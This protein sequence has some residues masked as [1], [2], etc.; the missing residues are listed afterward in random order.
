MSGGGGPGDVMS[1]VFDELANLQ[2]LVDFDAMD[3]V[4]GNV[5]TSSNRDDSIKFSPL[6]G[7]IKLLFKRSQIKNSQS[8]WV[9][10]YN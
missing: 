1:G 9:N 4:I 2:K 7:E 6:W 8:G 5:S 3:H 10:W